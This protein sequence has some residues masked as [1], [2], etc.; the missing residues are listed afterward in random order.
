MPPH[1][2]TAAG[3]AA[4]PR[5]HAPP[6]SRHSGDH[7]LR[8]AALGGTAPRAPSRPTRQ[9]TDRTDAPRPRTDPP[10]DPTLPSPSLHPRLHSLP[11]SVAGR[12][13]RRCST[14]APALSLVHIVLGAYT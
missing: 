13:S 9:T 7:P 12:K 10:P 8:P 5:P 2:G 6:D 4:S 3:R 14:T 1:S 11:A